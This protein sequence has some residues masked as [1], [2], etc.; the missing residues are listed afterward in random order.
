MELE[1]EVELFFINE[2]Q[3]T[4]ND[5]FYRGLTYCGQYTWGRGDISRLILIHLGIL[6]SFNDS[7]KISI[8]IT[9]DNK[10]FDCN[11]DMVIEA[12]RLQSDGYAEVAYKINVGKLQFQYM[13]GK[14]ALME[15]FR[16]FPEK[17]YIK[18]E[19]QVDTK[20]SRPVI[21]DK[22]NKIMSMVVR[23]GSVIID[24]GYCVEFFED[25]AK[26]IKK[27]I[28]SG[29]MLFSTDRIEGFESAKRNADSEYGHIFTFGDSSISI[30]ENGLLDVFGFIPEEIFYKI[31]N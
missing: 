12:L 17:F 19:N 21:Q 28:G 26:K 20:R 29:N 22:K 4:R 16:G 9:N 6:R 15:Y 2:N 14:R 8:T 13:I 24:E 30:C 27:H 1:N 23:N 7:K 11:N 25:F 31:E 10:R 18:I 3:G 5:R